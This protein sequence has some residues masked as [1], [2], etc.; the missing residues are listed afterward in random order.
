MASRTACTIATQDTREK[1]VHALV[2][3]PGESQEGMLRLTD[4]L[5]TE[6]L[7][8]LAGEGGREPARDDVDEDGLGRKGSDSLFEEL[9]G[10]D[11]LNEAHVRASIGSELQAVDGLVH[12]EHLR[13]VG[14]ANDDLSPD[15]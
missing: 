3:N 2:S 10:L 12:A 7:G 8:L 6:R 5:S 1:T 9:S 15:C 13:R 4:D 11:T 14:A